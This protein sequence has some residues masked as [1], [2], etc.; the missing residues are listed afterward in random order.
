MTTDPGDL[1][2]DPTCGSGSSAFTA[3]LYGRRW[4]TIDT[5]RVALAIARERLLT[6]TYPYFKLRD[7]SRGVDGGFEYETFTRT[8]L[9]SLANDEPAELIALIDRPRSDRKRVRVSGPFTVEALSRYASNPD[10]EASKTSQATGQ[11][12]NHVETLLSALQTQGVPRPGVKPAKITSL[13]PLSVAGALQA[14]GV[15]DLDGKPAK[16]AVSLGPR[17]G[18]I[19][20]TQVSEALAQAIGFSLIVFAGFAVD[21]EVQ[22]QLSTGKVGSTDV[23]L[24]LANNDLLVG[25]L[26]KNTSSSQTFRLYASPDVKLTKA[27]DGFHVEVLGVDSYD[28]ATGEVTSFG[29]TGIQAWFLDDAYDG[30]VFRVSQAFFPVS[31]GWEKLSKALRGTVDAELVED[32]HSW[33]SLPF[34]EPETGQIAVRV[35]ANDGNASEVIIRVESTT[36]A[37]E[38]A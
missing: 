15:V 24:L 7:E 5:S 9:G 20:M 34:D 1:V 32:L 31:D 37:R 35:I 19:T 22:A 36:S 28:A 26:L 30:R 16:F 14:E 3:E 29:K 2:L 13:S 25:D 8:T 12:S 6:A 4:I 10:V 38:E 21:S 33:K 17:F 27:K 18:S 11:A 23:A